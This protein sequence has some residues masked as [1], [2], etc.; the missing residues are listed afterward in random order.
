MYKAAVGV[1]GGGGCWSFTSAKMGLG[2]IQ[3]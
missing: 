1:G 2:W 3:F